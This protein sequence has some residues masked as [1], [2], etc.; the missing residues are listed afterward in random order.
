MD[1]SNT[2]KLIAKTYTAD[3]LGQM[4][5]TEKTTEVFCNVRSVTRDEFYAANKQGIRPEWRVTMFAPDYNGEETV[6]FNGSRYVVYRTYLGANE[7]L[8]LYL[9]SRVGA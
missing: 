4:I 1:K 6:E 9:A 5:P 8:E 3:N 2:V 7:Q